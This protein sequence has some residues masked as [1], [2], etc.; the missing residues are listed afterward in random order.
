MEEMGG[1]LD[2][3]ILP[4]QLGGTF[5]DWIKSG[6]SEIYNKTEKEYWF[7]Y[8]LTSVDVMF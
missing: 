2:S 3:S 5:L 8:I 7:S 1:N 4:E 6:K